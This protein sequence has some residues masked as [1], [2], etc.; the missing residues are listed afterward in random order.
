M[1]SKFK[2]LYVAPKNPNITSLQKSHDKRESNCS[3]VKTYRK[4]D[5]KSYCIWC[6]EVQLHH[7]NQRYCSE[8]CQNS[9]YAFTYPQK[10]QGLQVLLNRQ[11]YKCNICQHDWLPIVEQ[12]VEREKRDHP[13]AL[14]DVNQFNW[15]LMKRLKY[16][17]DLDSGRRPEVD[18]VK[19]I[20]AGGEPLGMDNHQAICH[21][22]HKEK[23]KKDMGL[24]SLY[25]KENK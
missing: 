17:H 11:D 6:T 21:T 19:P 25:K 15:A 5:G 23:T 9:M 20:A 18:H 12:I 22:C 1:M 10:E 24:I 2:Q 13:T 16:K 7:G 3:K 14:M 8:D 4:E